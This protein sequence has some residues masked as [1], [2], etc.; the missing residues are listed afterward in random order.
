MVTN[1]GYSDWATTDISPEANIKMFYRLSRR[2]KDFLIESSIDG[3]TY[4]QMR[5]FHLHNIKEE[6]RIGLYA[7]SPLNSSFQ[8][9]F[10]DI[11]FGKCVWKLHENLG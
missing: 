6:I 10:R 8:A 9:E 3:N 1:F 2:K 7:C 11:H 5:I 4:R